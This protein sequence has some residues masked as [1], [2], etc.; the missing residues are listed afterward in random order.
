MAIF[1]WEPPNRD[2]ECMWG[3]EKWRFWAYLPAVD[4]A[5]SEVLSTR[6]PVEHGYHLTSCDTYI[7]GRVVVHCV[8]S[9]ST[10][11]SPSPWFYSVRAT[12][13]ALAL[14]TIT[15]D[16]VWQQGLTLRRRQQ[17]R[18]E[19]Y[20]LV[21]PKLKYLIIKKLCSRYCTTDATKLTTDRHEASCC[22]FATVELL[23]T[24]VLSPKHTFVKYIFHLLI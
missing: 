22:L 7:A 5:T 19:F 15:I 11:K 8:Y 9:I 18:I 3:R 20:T 14:Y 10:I 6:S 1:R 2:V 23:V 4:T 24:T 21:N 17:N 16:R 13:R 12:K